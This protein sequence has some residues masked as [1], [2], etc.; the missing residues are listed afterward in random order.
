MQATPHPLVSRWRQ[1]D[2][3]TVRRPQTDAG[4]PR[5][6]AVGLQPGTLI[7]KCRREAPKLMACHPNGD[8]G[9]TPANAAQD[10]RGV[11]NSHELQLPLHPVQPLGHWEVKLLKGLQHILFC[12]VRV[13]LLEEPVVDLVQLIGTGGPGE[14]R[15]GEGQGVKIAQGT[16]KGGGEGRSRSS[17]PTPR[18]RGG[19]RGPAPPFCT[20]GSTKLGTTGSRKGFGFTLCENEGGRRETGRGV[21]K[22]GARRSCHNPHPPVWRV[23]PRASTSPNQPPR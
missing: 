23:S 21:G 12:A 10:P 14:G 9:W 13:V 4:D 20:Q 18:G 3:P 6:T 19:W 7:S 15:P 17:K 22:G 1:L 8:I 2:L 11:L 5:K 16:S